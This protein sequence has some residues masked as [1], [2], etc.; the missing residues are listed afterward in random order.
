MR[1]ECVNVLCT[2]FKSLSSMCVT[3]PMRMHNRRSASGRIEPVMKPMDSAR[4][5]SL[6]VAFVARFPALRK[7][8]P[9]ARCTPPGG[10]VVD[11]G[12]ARTVRRFGLRTSL[13]APLAEH[14]FLEIQASLGRY[15]GASQVGVYY[16]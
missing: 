7:A 1:R 16:S 6:F 2:T 4:V 11:F 14:L 10:M 8:R 13:F 15:R 3:E 9:A 12:R 5:S